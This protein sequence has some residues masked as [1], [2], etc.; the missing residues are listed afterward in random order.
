MSDDD[1]CTLITILLLPIMLLIGVC[2]FGIGMTLVDS[3]WEKESVE[4]G[5]AEYDQV[6]SEWQWKPNLLKDEK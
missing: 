1:F 4:K 5:F 6:T 3:V 2:S